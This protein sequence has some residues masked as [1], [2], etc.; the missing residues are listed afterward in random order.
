MR[1]GNSIIQM[2]DSKENTKKISPNLVQKEEARKYTKNTDFFDKPLR[3]S[4]FFQRVGA[5][6]TGK[7][8]ELKQKDQVIDAIRG[9]IAENLAN[10]DTWYDRITSSY[11]GINI[12]ASLKNDF[13]T[14]TS[15]ACNKQL[16]G[17]LIGLN[18]KFNAK[19]DDYNKTLAGKWVKNDLRKQLSDRVTELKL[20]IR[21]NEQLV[22]ELRTSNNKQFNDYIKKNDASIAKHISKDVKFNAKEQKDNNVVGKVVVQE[23][24][25]INKNIEGLKR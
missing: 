4:S 23:L 13:D 14:I 20:Y 11:K 22:K 10:G 2:N 1:R 16:V 15:D 18:E 7:R 21:H 17:K 24:N 5:F 12:S 3:K 9:K 19:I 25:N 6:F 8:E